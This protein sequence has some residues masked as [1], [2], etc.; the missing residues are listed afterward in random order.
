GGPATD[1]QDSILA[2]DWDTG[3][4]LWQFQAL[5]HDIC[6][7]DFAANSVNFVYAGKSYVVAG[8]KYGMVYGIEPPSTRTGQP[9]VV[10]STRITGAGYLNTGAVFQPPAYRDGMIF[11]SGG[12]TLDGACPKGAVWALDAT[13]GIP[14]WRHCTAEPEVLSNA[15][16][17]DVLFIAD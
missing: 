16:S 13:T 15:L 3:A 12:P 7:C 9:K 11:I 1:E 10:W 6:D 14:R 5:H 4:V 8:N 2:L 17:D